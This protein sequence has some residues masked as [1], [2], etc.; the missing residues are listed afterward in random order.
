MAGGAA[1]YVSKNLKVIHRP[2]I[3]F[4]MPQVESCWVELQTS[5][6]PIIVGCVYRHPHAN[7][8][9]FSAQMEDIIKKFNDN[10]QIAYI[11][12]DFNIDFLKYV[13]HL[14]TENYINMLYSNNFY[15][16][17]TKPTRI[18]SHS[19]TLI[20]HIYTNSSNFDLMSGILT[21]DITD[22]LPVF[23]L[24]SNNTK[25]EKTSIYYRDYSQFNK[26]QYLYDLGKVKWNDM[27]VDNDINETTRNIMKTIHKIID[28]YAPIKL[29]SRRKMKQM[30]KPWITNGILKSVK[31]K[32]KLYQA[33]LLNPHDAEK[34]SKYKKYSNLLNNIIKNRKKVYITMQFEANKS[35][36]KKTWK[37]IGHIIKR[38]TKAQTIPSRLV[39]GD[40]VYMDK[41]DI[42]DQFNNY[43]SNIGSE[44]ASKISD[45]GEDAT[46][47]IYNTPVSSF[48]LTP[49][50]RSEIN[51]R[52]MCL[53]DSKS[54]PDI[55]YNLIK[56]ANKEL[57]E[58]IAY[59]INESIRNGIVPDLFKTSCI[60]PIFKSGDMTDPCNYRPIAVLPALN[61][62]LE[63]VIYDQL[64]KF[65]DHHKII[66]HHQFGFRKNHST[67]QATLELVDTLRKAID[68]KEI[69]CGIFL[70]FTKAFDTVDHGILLRKLYKYGIRGLA[71]NWFSNYLTKRTQYVRI[72]DI[73]SSLKEIKYGVPQGSTLG[74]LLFLLYINDLPN[75]SHK[76]N[77]RMFADDTN[78]FY[79]NSDSAIVQNVINTELNNVYQYCAANKLTIN[80]KK[81]NYMIIKSAKKNNAD[82]NIQ[83]IEQKE[84]VKYLG[85]YIDQHLS[86]EQQIKFVHSKISKNVGIISRLRHYMSLKTLVNIYY[87]LIYPYLSY[88]ILSWG[89]TY[90]TKLAR[91]CSMQNKCIRNIFFTNRYEHALPLYNVLNLLIFNNIFIFKSA[92]FAYQ[93]INIKSRVPVVFLKM[94]KPASEQ[95]SHN[96]RYA[97]KGNLVRPAVRTNYGKFTFQFS[98]STIWEKIPIYIKKSSSLNIF[99]NNLKMHLLQSQE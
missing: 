56:T 90:K 23:C 86:W 61:K 84:F 95:H 74:P 97:A 8:D 36:L 28:K 50:S 85:I 96:T 87:S 29:A 64:M 68:N 65:L 15:P 16:I 78:I 9:D 53:D 89:S 99:K 55:P 24:V 51:K 5:S 31:Q 11:L 98:I 62:I 38:K 82:I 59:I 45:T 34:H 7:L 93:I 54:S 76:L 92:T 91:I 27:Y 72:S 69:T 10:K 41:Q 60:T 39:I 58:P 77:F 13:N 40:N 33:S 32:Q 4:D 12:G 6:N 66:H 3:K 19:A 25:K 42:A 35:N 88:G 57:T 52:I 14:P 22:H 70:D 44:L 73:K 80:F 43:F 67:E 2:D 37:I 75:V 20:D 83:Q 46:R 1:L 94:L 30:Q 71:H 81:T 47:H 79:S 63:R 17:I 21:L 48:F 18:T 26:E 49:V